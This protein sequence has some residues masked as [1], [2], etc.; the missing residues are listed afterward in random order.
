MP[1]LEISD[2]IT[3][4]DPATG[5]R[6]P[7]RRDAVMRELLEVGDGRAAR[8]VGKIPEEDGVLDPGAVD[9]VLIRAHT[10]LQRLNEELQM[11][12]Q[13]AELLDPILRAVRT[14]GLSIAR[15]RVV[16]VGCGLGYVIRW[17]AATG[18]LGDV[19]LC[20]VD[21]NRVLVDRA[22]ELAAVEG[23]DCR[24]VY[25]DAFNLPEPATVY[26][27]SGVLHHMRRADLRAFFQAQA[28]SEAIAYCHFDIAAT[29]LAPIGA[30]I[31]HRARMREPLGRHDGVASARRAH[32]DHELMAAAA[33]TGLVAMLYRP[34]L[35]TNPFCASVRPIL[36]VRPEL[37]GDLHAA[38]GPEARHLVAATE[39]RDRRPW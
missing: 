32:D 12:A 36:G 35:H 3:A 13:V 4:Y 26:I 31:F 10:E 21:L 34:V 27:S 20:G 6:L 37:V 17:L 11:G 8:I 38:F 9:R 22:G 14:A 39:P 16:D 15:P 24:F 7:V 30:W 33:G 23:L 5:A 1:I 28:T 2:L 25:G 18:V 19:E 29:R